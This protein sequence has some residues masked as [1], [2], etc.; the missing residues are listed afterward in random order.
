MC[1]IAGDIHSFGDEVV[2]TWHDKAAKG[3]KIETKPDQIN[4]KALLE[5]CA[6][7]RDLDKADT[8]IVFTHSMRGGVYVE[9][10]YSIATD[11]HID[12]I[13]NYSNIFTYLFVRY[14]SWQD[15]VAKVYHGVDDN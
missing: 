6:D 8:V 12:V 4:T 5:A 2:S 11:K 3:L 15:Y 9:L 14:E 10:G 13:G 1:K 7:I